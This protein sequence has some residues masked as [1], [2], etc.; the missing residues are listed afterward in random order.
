M[1]R[2]VDGFHQLI[3][4]GAHGYAGNITIALRHHHP[5]QILFRRLLARALE[6]RYSPKR[7]RFAALT[8]GVGIDLRIHHEDIDVLTLGNY[9]IKTSEADIV[10]PS[11]AAI[12]PDRLSCQLIFRADNL[13][14]QNP[15]ASGKF[16]RFQRCQQRF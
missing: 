12:H 14:L 3:R 4:I 11:I 9:M 5:P 15:A 2:F 8:A 10:S 1:L 16:R 6:L 13:F 7:R